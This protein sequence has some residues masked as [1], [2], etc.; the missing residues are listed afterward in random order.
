MA[1]KAPMLDLHA[2]P[3]REAAGGRLDLSGRQ[4]KASRSLSIVSEPVTT[5]C[6]GEKR[7]HSRAPARRQRFDDEHNQLAKRSKR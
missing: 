7:P 4:P 1:I 6:Q 3:K 2:T 5:L